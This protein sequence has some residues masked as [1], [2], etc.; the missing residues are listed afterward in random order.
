MQHHHI[1]QYSVRIIGIPEKEER[2]KGQ[3]AFQ[4]NNC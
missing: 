1:L 4:R 3:E 2:E